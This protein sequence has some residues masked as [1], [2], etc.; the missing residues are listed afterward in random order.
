MAADKL[1]ESNACTG[2]G[3]CQF[4]QNKSNSKHKKDRCNCCMNSRLVN[5]RDV[6]SETRTRAK[7]ALIDSDVRKVQSH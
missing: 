5:G 2:I 1:S 3:C 7:E 6:P 4:W